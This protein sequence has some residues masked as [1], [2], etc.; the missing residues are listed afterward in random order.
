[1]PQKIFVLGLPGSGKSTISRYILNYMQKYHEEYSATRICDYD[2]LYQMFKDDTNHKSFYPTPHDG[3]YV[4]DPSM[5]DLALKKL[6]EMVVDDCDYA[7]K[8]LVVIEFARTDYTNAFKIFD[9]TFLHDAFFLFLDVDIETGM[10]R[11][12]DRVKRPVCRDNHFVS[13]FTFEF[14]RQKDNA[15]H[16]SLETLHLMKKYKISSDNIKIL[17]NRGPERGFWVVVNNLIKRVV[18]DTA[19]V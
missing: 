13:K 8:D 6:E 14:Y 5:Y 1:M 4:N 18:K 12:K 7:G 19:L 16:L 2:I 3:F 15:K 10:K 17:N 9:P 11:V